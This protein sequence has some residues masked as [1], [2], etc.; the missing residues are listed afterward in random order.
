MAYQKTYARI[1]WENYPSDKTPLNEDNLNKVDVATN[2]IDDRV[3]HLDLNKLDKTEAADF[4]KDFTIDK[5]TG[6]ITVTR[7]NNTQIVIDTALEKIAV[8]FKYDAETQKLV[9]TLD[10][11]EMQY[12]DL[13]SL[14]T[15]FEFINS[16][17]IEFIVDAD[18]KVTAKVIEG[19]ISEKH[20][21]PDYL[22]DIK[23]ESA[24]AEASAKAAEQ[25]A[26]NSS[27][28]ADLSKSWAV[29]T[30][31]TVRQGDETDNSKYHSEQSKASSEQA[32]QYVVQVEQK[33]QQAIDDIEQK[34]NEIA[35]KIEN[36]YEVNAPKFRV[37]L[38]TGHLL[39]EADSYRYLFTVNRDNGHLEWGLAV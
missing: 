25:S 17:T 13:A 33:T 23:V 4:I 34:G 7:Y 19:S 37:N 9:L 39:F 22:A 20:L 5:M 38:E 16:E 36:A 30:E 29:G 6:V 11:G 35:D 28:F 14:I 31:G 15:Q 1:N 32:R 21:R 27:N 26:T 2:E 3:I 12:I 24:K 18:G 10:N 8:N